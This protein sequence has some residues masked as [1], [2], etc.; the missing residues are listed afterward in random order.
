M[1]DISAAKIRSARLSNR[2]RQLRWQLRQSEPV[3]AVYRVELARDKLLNK[4]ID[5][6]WLS[7]ADSWRRDSIERALSIAIETLEFP[8]RG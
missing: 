4:L 7:E 3:R 6:G 5:A 1:A 8:R 2:K